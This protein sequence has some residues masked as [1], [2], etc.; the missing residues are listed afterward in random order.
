MAIARCTYVIEFDLDDPDGICMTLGIASVEGVRRLLQD[1][2]A[3][4]AYSDINASD[5]DIEIVE[6]R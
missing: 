2:F 3:D 5:F 4:G 6:E 1:D